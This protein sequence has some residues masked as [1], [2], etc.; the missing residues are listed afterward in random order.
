MT[1]EE[2]LSLIVDSINEARKIYDSNHVEFG[3]FVNKFK[4]LSG[5]EIITILRKLE[6]EKILRVCDRPS[7]LLPI[8]SIP[9]E[10]FNKPTFIKSFMLDVFDNFDQWVAKNTD[11]VDIKK[12]NDLNFYNFDENKRI[13]NINN[14]EFKFSKDGK[15]L[16]LLKIIIKKPK[17]LY[18]DD[19]L[20]K[21]DGGYT[22]I[23]EKIKD[24]YYQLCRGIQNK[25]SK[26]GILNF[27]EFDYN[28]VKI[29]D[30]Y[31]KN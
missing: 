30:I 28:Q 7:S 23:N 22:K 17:C 18:Y 13:L 25:L 14:K 24:N 4:E 1:Y 15:A 20:E 3:V 9:Y 19:A 21:I 27:L 29:N 5:Y 26:K 12:T 8:D 6:R 2:K 31:K 16:S 11:I 10:E